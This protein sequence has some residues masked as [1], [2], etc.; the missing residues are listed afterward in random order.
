MGNS[1]RFWN[2]LF[3]NLYCKNK[4]KNFG[5]NKS[6]NPVSF[7]NYILWIFV[8]GMMVDPHTDFVI[9]PAKKLDRGRFD[10]YDKIWFLLQGSLIKWHSKYNL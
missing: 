6:S 7:Q 9:F 10:I 1:K 5:P 3:Y 2:F 4:G 8:P